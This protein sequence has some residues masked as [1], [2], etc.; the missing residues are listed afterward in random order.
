MLKAVILHHGSP[1][2]KEESIR[3]VIET[4]PRLKTM[5]YGPIEARQ[6]AENFHVSAEQSFQTL[7]QF[8]ETRRAPELAL[9]YLNPA[10]EIGITIGDSVECALF[11][12]NGKPRLE[13][14]P[15]Q[16]PDFIF[17]I[18]PE[19]V[20]VLTERTRDEIGDIGANVLKEMLAGNISMRVVSGPLKLLKHGYLEM[21]RLAGSNL[22]VPKILS[23]LKSLKS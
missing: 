3:D 15:A 6:N 9:R 2:T 18:R 12:Q 4:I 8:F 13:E 20:V 7:K 22:S 16:N 11:Y 5:S 1:P 14:R 17:S 21:I 23:T 19:T 10:V